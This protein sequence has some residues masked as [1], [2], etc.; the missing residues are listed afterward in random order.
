[1]LPNKVSVCPQKWKLLSE[2]PGVSDIDQSNPGRSS[3]QPSSKR[4]MCGWR[5]DAREARQRVCLDKFEGI[6]AVAARTHRPN[7]DEWLQS[8]LKAKPMD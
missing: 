5:I 8:S 2:V 4:C 1:M 6:M 3:A 7:G